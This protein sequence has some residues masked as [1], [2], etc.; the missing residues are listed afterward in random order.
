M[1]A[2]ASQDG[3]SLETR[4]GDVVKVKSDT[5][6]FEGVVISMVDG[7]LLVDFGN[8]DI[9]KV[10]RENCVR[11]LRWHTIEVGDA[12]HV[13][14]VNG[15]NNYVATVTRVEVDD[16]GRPTYSVDYGGGGGADEESN[17]NCLR[18]RKLTSERSTPLKPLHKA[19]NVV[20]AAN[21]FKQGA[22]SKAAPLPFDWKTGD[23]VR[24][25]RGVEGIIEQ[26]EDDG[27]CLIYVDEEKRSA[28][29]DRNDILEKLLTW[30][31]IEVGDTVKAKAQGECLWFH[32]TVTHVHDGPL[33]A[34]R[35]L[36]VDD[37]PQPSSSEGCNDSVCDETAT[38]PPDRIRKIESK[39][40]R[41]LKERWQSTR[42]LTSPLVALRARRSF[43]Q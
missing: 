17:V 7:G 30:S 1:G 5:L 11:I 25:R 13:R 36:D 6:F 40:H 29:L 42:R 31:H 32:A 35:W 22:A 33:Y 18:V 41:H 43:R 16:E 12:V 20:V 14:E 21:L 24:T 9:R 10:P 15:K 3:P 19:V 34:I 37:D 39:R 28:W 27:R 23:V 8:N 4:V 26:I 2:A 38:I